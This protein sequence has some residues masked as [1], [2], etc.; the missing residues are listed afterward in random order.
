MT[1]R[2]WIWALPLALA[3]S[4]STAYAADEQEPADSMQHEESTTDQPTMLSDEPAC[5]AAQ[6]SCNGGEETKEESSE[7]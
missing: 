3:A 1:S 4:M 6:S 2:V 7:K 5:D